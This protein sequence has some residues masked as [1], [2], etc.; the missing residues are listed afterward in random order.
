LNTNPKSRISLARW[1]IAHLF[2]LWTKYDFAFASRQTEMAMVNFDELRTRV[3]RCVCEQ[4]AQTVAQ[5][6]LSK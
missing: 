6:F 2:Q 1:V 5:P 4:I 3:T